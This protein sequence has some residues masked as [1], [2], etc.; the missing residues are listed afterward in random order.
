MHS[1]SG[2]RLKWLQAKM[3]NKRAD[4]AVQRLHVPQPNIHNSQNP[5]ISNTFIAFLP[6][7]KKQGREKIANREIA[8]AHDR[9][10]KLN[11]EI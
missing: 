2:Y 5:S 1:R 4:F 11:F 6:S 10:Y 7:A 9:I 8:T 3:A